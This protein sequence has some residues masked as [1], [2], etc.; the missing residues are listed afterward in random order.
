[1]TTWTDPKSPVSKHF[2]VA[3]VTSGDPRRIPQGTALRRRIR[4]FARKLD[5]VWDD[6][7]PLRINSWYR[8]AAVNRAVGG[9]ANSRH[10][11]G[12]AADLTL[13]KGTARQKLKFEEALD[14]S[15]PGGIGRGHKYGKG[16]LHLDTGAKR[17]WNYS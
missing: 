12:D 10:I 14:N 4:V 7:G 11:E 17:R 9:A 8:P 13:K 6:F 15:W 5:K 1:M 16:Y 2:T 3:D